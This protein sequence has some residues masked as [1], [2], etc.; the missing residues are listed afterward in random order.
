MT[1]E[2]D[3]K[4]EQVLYWSDYGFDPYMRRTLPIENINNDNQ[5]GVP[6]DT[7]TQPEVSEMFGDSTIPGSKIQVGSILARQISVGSQPFAQNVVFDSNSPDTLN[8]SA[9]VLTLGSGQQ[10][11]TNSGSLSNVFRNTTAFNTDS[12]TKLLVHFDETSGSSVTDSSSLANTGTS[13][14]ST[15]SNTQSRFG[16]Y[17]RNFN[18]TNAY[19]SFPYNAAYDI[20]GYIQLEASVYPSSLA[21]QNAIITKGNGTPYNNVNYALS[22]NT[23]GQVQFDYASSLGTLHTY[24]TNA[25]IS[26]SNWYDIKLVYTYAVTGSMHIYINNVEYPGTWTQGTGKDPAS[27]G[28]SLP[29]EVGG[30]TLN[31]QYF[32]GYIDEVRI[33][34]GYTYTAITA[35]TNTVLLS[36]YDETSGTAP[37]DSS[38]NANTG[39]STSA[40]ASNTKARLGTYSRFFNA[41]GSKITYSYISAYNISTSIQIEASFNTTS[42]TTYQALVVKGNDTAVTYNYYVR[43]GSRGASPVTTKSIDFGYRGTDGVYHEFYT[44]NNVVQS[45]TWYDLKI[46]YTYGTPGSMRM[47]LNGALLTGTWTNGTGAVGVTP[48]ND[49]IFV[50]NNYASSQAFTGYIDEVRIKNSLDTITTPSTSGTPYYIYYYAS[51]TLLTSTANSDTQGDQKLLLAIWTPNSVYGKSSTQI[52]R[53]S[54]TTITGDQIVTG[55]IKSNDGRTI[56]DLS[57][58]YIKMNDGAYDRLL[59][60]YSKNGF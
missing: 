42:A 26:A 36:H 3:T 31:S 5:L 25:V 56:F 22:I 12:D 6:S 10:I 20:A 13:T 15:A 47:Y 16:S 60:G 44:S 38:S 48:A 50:G 4:T 32:S 35:D 24:K 52:F 37:S 29:V 18:G 39:T 54:G 40:A 21:S 27:T 58:Q 55:A 34:S 11:T 33:K 19:V 8:W 57:N 14:N 51:P 23:L 1:P 17:S 43:V 30:F 53:S 7:M 59:L 2:Q 41:A 28:G 9:G 45:N 49:N 46:Q